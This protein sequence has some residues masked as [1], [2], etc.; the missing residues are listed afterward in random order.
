MSRG[1][2]RD[3]QAKAA[4]TVTASAPFEALGAALQTIGR[5]LLIGVAAPLRLRHVGVMAL[6]ALA[7]TVWAAFA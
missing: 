6:A 3:T 1:E 2:C 7:V 4:Q 5:S